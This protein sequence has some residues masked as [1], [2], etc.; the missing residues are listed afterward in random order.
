MNTNMGSASVRR[1]FFGAIAFSGKA[2][3]GFGN[4]L[5]GIG[6]D[7]INWPAGTEIKTAADVPPDTL[8]NLGIL[9]GPVVA[10]FAIVSVWCYSHYKLTRE[11]HDFILDELRTRRGTATPVD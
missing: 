11:R 2:T 4:F 1:E 5:G 10:A 6:L 7:I 9:Y 8:V 3:S